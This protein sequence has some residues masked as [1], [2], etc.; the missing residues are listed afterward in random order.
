MEEKLKKKKIQLQLRI[1]EIDEK[2]VDINKKVQEYDSILSD[3]Y[4]ERREIVGG[5]KTLTELIGK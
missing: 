5:I 1:Q 3:L 2:I 4:E